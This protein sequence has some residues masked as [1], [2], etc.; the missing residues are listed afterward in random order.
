MFINCDN[1]LRL[2]RV[3][4]S[5][6]SI[7]SIEMDWTARV[8]FPAGEEIFLCS[9]VARLTLGLTQ[10]F[11]QWVLGA[12]SPGVEHPGNEADHSP[13]SSA[14]VKNDGAIPPLQ[15]TSWWHGS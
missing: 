14:E 4:G 8:Q 15:H 9:T 12:L 3:T 11:V 7:V 13:P 5:W 10:P 2:L 6:D 1:I